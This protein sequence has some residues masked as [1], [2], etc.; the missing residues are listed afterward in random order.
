MGTR[1]S[2]G[3]HYRASL[4]RSEDI[5]QRLVGMLYRKYALVI[6]GGIRVCIDGKTGTKIKA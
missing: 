6:D 5:V 4:I 2:L 1:S 3:R